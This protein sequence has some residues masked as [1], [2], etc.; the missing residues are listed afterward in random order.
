MK[1][2]MFLVTLDRRGFEALLVAALNPECARIFDGWR[3]DA[4]SVGASGYIMACLDEPR[5]AIRLSIEQL[6]PAVPGT[7]DVRRLPAD[8]ARGERAFSD[9]CHFNLA[10]PVRNLRGSFSFPFFRGSPR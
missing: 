8:Q 2:A 1:L 10:P 4:G 5:F 9:C 7:V 6:R 3:Q